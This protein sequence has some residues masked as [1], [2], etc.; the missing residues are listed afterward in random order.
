[1]A[2]E[3]FMKWNRIEVNWKLLKDK[4]AFGLF[5][6]SHDDSENHDLIDA[7]ITAVGKTDEGRPAAF[8]PDHRGRRSEFSLHIGS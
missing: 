1:M 2:Q 6:S 5:R 3:A 7:G 4:F 8:H